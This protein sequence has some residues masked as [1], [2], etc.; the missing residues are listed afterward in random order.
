MSEYVRVQEFVAHATKVN[1]SAIGQYSKQV[2]AT[3]GD[4]M[5]VNIWRVGS[6]ENIW[7][8]NYNKAPIDCVC[9][10]S[11]EQNV[12]SGARNGSIKVFDL[13]EGK[14]A[15]TLTGHQVSVTS[16]QYHPYGEFLI[17]GS[18]DCTMKFWDLRSKSCVE[19]YTGHK[20]D[21]TCVRFSP[22]GK[23]VASAAKDGLMNFF[24]LIAT[25]H[26]NSIRT[27]PSYINTFEFNPLELAV[28]GATSSRYVRVWNLD[29]MSVMHTTP[30]ESTP[31]SAL[32]IPDSGSS[33][34]TTSRS[35]VKIWD[36]DDYQLKESVDIGWSNIADMRVTDDNMIVATSFS[37][38]FVSVWEVDVDQ[39]IENR[40][41]TPAGMD[42][43]RRLSL[44]PAVAP[45]KGNI[46]GKGLSIAEKMEQIKQD[47]DNYSAIYGAGAKEA[48]SSH[49]NGPESKAVPGRQDARSGAKG[50]PSRD[51]DSPSDFGNDVALDDKPVAPQVVVEN[52]VDM[53]ASLGESF[54]QKMALQKKQQQDPSATELRREIARDLGE[55][56]GD[57]SGIA[58]DDGWND[59]EE[60][61]FPNDELEDLLPPSH[62]NDKRNVHHPPAM[63]APAPIVPIQKADAKVALTDASPQRIAHVTAAPP[64]GSTPTAAAGGAAARRYGEGAKVTNNMPTPEIYAPT[65]GAAAGHQDPSPSHQYVAAGKAIRLQSPE[66]KAPSTAAGRGVGTAAGGRA[67]EE[68]SG[69]SDISRC[70]ELIDQLCASSG[71][72]LSTLSQRLVTVKLLRQTWNKGEIMG[73]LEHLEVLGD[74]MVLDNPQNASIIVDFLMGVDFQ[75]NFLSL[76][77]CVKLLPIVDSVVTYTTSR[78][79]PT[80]VIVFACYKTLVALAQGFGELIRNTR[81][82]MVA[83]GVDLSR[84]ERLNKCNLCYQVFNKAK[85]RLDIVRHQ[86]RQHSRVVTVLSEYQRLANTYF[87]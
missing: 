14:L 77:A 33:L 39:F 58:D 29:S 52:R 43:D 41:N 11:T 71:S 60:I 72:T 75:G 67:V 55:D 44:E 56:G 81:S 74:A 34:Y 30:A 51:T 66:L 40:Q 86:Y 49:N 87:P 48:A 79:Q 50:V 22:D 10:D 12:V 16:M 57:N 42:K 7:S 20:K 61:D 8:L 54:W 13:N 59:D 35:G 82:A 3:G 2:I 18:A 68:G 62:F 6:V 26:I 25:K 73:V 17:T 24:D 5:K 31:I 4:D 78:V 63:A 19:T 53:A 76:D 47:Y 80:D 23:W 38:N 70:H 15:R 83:G 64:K 65:R 9:F 85:Q 36:L 32:S 69:A 27:A 37:S 45:G 21:V 28:I 84:E 46:A 1:C